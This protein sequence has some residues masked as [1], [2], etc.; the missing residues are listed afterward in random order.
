MGVLV[1]I[2]R[3]LLG[4]DF[5]KAPKI[6]GDK[7]RMWLGISEVYWEKADFKFYEYDANRERL[8]NSL[9]NIDLEL[10]LKDNMLVAYDVSVDFFISCNSENTQITKSF[11]WCFLGYDVVGTKGA[12]SLITEM[13]PSTISFLS[14]T[15]SNYYFS[16]L[17]VFGLCDD[18]DL[19]NRYAEK[20]NDPA[21]PH[22]PFASV[23][24]WVE[25]NS[26]SS[27]LSPS[28]KPVQYRLQRSGS[29][30]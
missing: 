15:Q 10:M 12:S 21:E 16:N 24:V 23:G 17:N 20:F 30:D 14:D 6:V 18:V 3:K 29:D 13:Y 26:F 1:K 25:K 9:Q 5:R 2:G 27:F 7:N 11:E 28:T 19:A 4:Y 8:L 22:A